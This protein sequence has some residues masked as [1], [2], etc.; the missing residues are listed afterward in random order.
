MIDI[1]IHT[2]AI[3]FYVTFNFPTLMLMKYT[4]CDFT[5]KTLVSQNVKLID[6]SRSITNILLSYLSH[7]VIQKWFSTS[8]ILLLLDQKRHRVFCMSYFLNY[9]NYKWISCYHQIHLHPLFL[10]KL[11][12]M[13]KVM[14]FKKKTLNSQSLESWLL[15]CNS[16][17]EFL[18][19]CAF[20]CAFFQS[21]FFTL[22]VTPL[23]SF[24]ENSS[25]S[26]WI[27]LN[28]FTVFFSIALGKSYWKEKRAYE[29]STKKNC[30]R[31]MWKVCVDKFL[32]LLYFD[33]CVCIQWRMLSLDVYMKGVLDCI[34]LKVVPINKLWFSNAFLLARIGYQTRK[35]LYIEWNHRLVCSVNTVHH[36]IFVFASMF[37]LWFI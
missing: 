16:F 13:W 8:L 37:Y 24:S 31:R 29:K 11:N 33:S 25:V 3:T 14:M 34:H 17:M 22:I 18:K 10:F 1:S 23:P 7:K 36:S 30:W 5:R 12:F 32:Q 20:W 21:W 9:K 6:V 26:E 35:N 2:Q 4:Q 19:K 27:T 15:S 28:F